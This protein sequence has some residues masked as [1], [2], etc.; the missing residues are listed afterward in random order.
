[1]VDRGAKSEGILL[2]TDFPGPDDTDHTLVFNARGTRL[3]AACGAAQ[4]VL[5]FDPRSG[6]EVA[7]LGKLPC[8][9]SLAFLS[10]EVLL[11]AQH[12]HYKGERQRPGRCVRWDLRRGSHEIVL[13]GAYL[14]NVAVSPNGRVVAIG[15][16]EGPVPGYGGSWNTLFSCG[17]R[18]VAANVADEMGKQDL[19]TVWNA[20]DGRRQRTFE[21]A[22]S[23]RLVGFRGD[24]LTL[25][26]G[27]SHHGLLLYKEDEG[28]E[29][30]ATYPLDDY[31]N[32][33][34]F[35]SRAIAVL[36][37]RGGLVFLQ[38][39]TGR[40]QRQRT[41]PADRV[42]RYA[43]PSADWSTFAAATEGGVFVWKGG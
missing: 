14:L 19:I 12:H 39:E 1:M 8:L 37:D 21:A 27:G 35:R 6:R 28:E 20:L 38:A 29:P 31:A 32:A 11:I 5:V 43:T 30:A 18:Y 26:V 41:P 4:H 15:G 34:Q 33:V 9:S 10:P 2:A 7:R 13:E 17:G 22:Q 42:L 23:A 24:T 40:I 3:A 36:L 25:A 16:N